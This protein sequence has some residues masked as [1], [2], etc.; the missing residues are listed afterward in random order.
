MYIH[1]S[2]RNLYR[3]IPAASKFGIFAS[4]PYSVTISI[5]R[6]SC[7]FVR[8]ESPVEISRRKRRHSY[9][10]LAHVWLYARARTRCTA[11]SLAAFV[12]YSI[13]RVS[14]SSLTSRFRFSSFFARCISQA[15]RHA[16]ACVR[17]CV[18][19][20]KAVCSTCRG[21]LPMHANPVSKLSKCTR[22]CITDEDDGWM[23]E[24]GERGQKGR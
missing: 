7:S 21:S 13:S 19:W 14:L 5:F 8:L 23:K 11:P 1:A 15:T 16:H 6:S 2:Y 17:A 22:K 12:V 9:T 20:A 18:C 4:R 3:K 10:C 24:P